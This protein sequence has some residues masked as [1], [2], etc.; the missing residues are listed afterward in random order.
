VLHDPY[1]PIVNGSVGGE[2]NLAQLEIEQLSNLGNELI[3]GR[4]FDSGGIRKFNQLRAQSYGSHS[5]V[6]STIQKTK[7]DVIHTHNLSQRS[8]YKWM[9]QTD[10]PIVSSIHNYR[11]FCASSI[12]WRNGHNCFE[13]RDKSAISALRHQCDGA[14][15][16][17]NASRHLFLQPSHPQIHSPKLFLTGSEM[18]NTA[19]SP[20]IPLNKMRILRNPGLANKQ[21]KHPGRLR[22]GWL[23]AGRFVEEKGI[24]DLIK[25][26][27]SFEYL[28]LAG[29]GPLSKE[30]ARLI[31]SR[32]QIR[33]IGTFPP[34]TLAIYYSY[35]GLIFSSTWL[36]GSPLVIA[37]ALST[38]T[39]V[40]ALDVSAAKE[41]VEL[42]QAG[43]VV[44]GTLNVAKLQS[45]FQNIRS[46]SVNY[47]GNALM[48]AETHFSIENWTSLLNQYLSEATS[49]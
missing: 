13:C 17:I 2:D 5:E 47:S 22:K 26:W 4:T 40:I 24:I 6:L 15:G 9:H 3:D 28:D 7:P 10:V 35:E 18:M 30:I 27:P 38:G 49:L 16:A 32:P 8:G 12:A 34:G 21:R 31:K 25:N 11:L 19:L 20:I 1:K 29:S 43:V 39:P 48:A 45:A 36:E 37:D 44:E 23:F 42:S 33:M 41:Q 46:N 14:R